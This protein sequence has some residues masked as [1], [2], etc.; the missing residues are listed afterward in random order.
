MDV[1]IFK[2]TNI[3]LMIKRKLFWFKGTFL[4][5]TCLEGRHLG[6]KPQISNTILILINENLLLFD[7]M[8]KQK[9]LFYFFNWQKKYLSYYS[10][11]TFHLIS[12]CPIIRNWTL[13]NLTR[14]HKLPWSFL[15]ILALFATLF[16]ALTQSSLRGQTVQTPFTSRYLYFQNKPYSSVCVCGPHRAIYQS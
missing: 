15:C 16:P 14:Q 11:N 8:L 13:E 12:K 1:W 6:N 10:S 7:S 9:L 4:E 2:N 5:V 3:L